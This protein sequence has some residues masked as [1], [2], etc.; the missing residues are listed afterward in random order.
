MSLIGIGQGRMNNTTPQT[1]HQPRMMGMGEADRG[2]TTPPRRVQTQDEEDAQFQRELEE[3]TRRS[4]EEY[5]RRL[6]EENNFYRRQHNNLYDVF[7]RE[8]YSG[9]AGSSRRHNTDSEEE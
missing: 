4:R 3:A 9:G 2:I 8:A 5:V 7:S 6:E 1:M